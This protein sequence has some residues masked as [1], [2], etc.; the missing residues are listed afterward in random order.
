MRL[1]RPQTQRC[2]APKMKQR[3]LICSGWN[4]SRSSASLKCNDKW[5][6]LYWGA[7]VALHVRDAPSPVSW[8]RSSLTRTSS[9]WA[10]DSGKCA[11]YRRWDTKI[12]YTSP[13]LDQIHIDTN[14]LLCQRDGRGA[15]PNTQCS[16]TISITWW[17]RADHIRL[18]VGRTQL[19]TWLAF[20]KHK[21][22]SEA[23]ICWSSSGRGWLLWHPTHSNYA[24]LQCQREGDTWPQQAHIVTADCLA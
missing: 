19:R 11:E 12:V 6:T 8:F 10:C 7:G 21:R 22:S 1:R 14:A 3:L 20:P 4:A 18:D 13:L 5:N 24:R 15:W 17:H 16:L 2:C 9:L 23:R